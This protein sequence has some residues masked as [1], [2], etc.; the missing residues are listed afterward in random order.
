MGRPRGPSENKHNQKDPE[1]Y[2][3]D[4]GCIYSNGRGCLDCPFPICLYELSLRERKQMLEGRQLYL[5]GVGV[6]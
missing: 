2:W 6:H 5:F 4:D 1:Y 3:R